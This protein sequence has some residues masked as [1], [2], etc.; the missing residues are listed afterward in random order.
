MVCGALILI[1]GA[2]FPLPV[3][4]AWSS[5]PAAVR[6]PEARLYSLRGAPPVYRYLQQLDEGSIAAHFPF[7]LPERE[8]QYGYYAML[9]GTSIINGYSGAFPPTYSMRD[10]FLGNPAADPQGVEMVLSVD[11]VT[12]VVVHRDAYITDYGERVLA[13]L[14][15]LGWDVAVEFGGD[16]VLTRVAA[17][18]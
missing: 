9:H 17:R 5:A 3:N 13:V 18:R 7:G 14:Q 11:Q 4:G 10:Q 16:V 1:E 12:H 8:I 15:Q 2:A 6:P